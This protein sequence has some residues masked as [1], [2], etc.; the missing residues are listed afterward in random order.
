MV[1]IRR[2]NILNYGGQKGELEISRKMRAQKA[3][4]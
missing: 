1:D 3:N 4:N 2:C